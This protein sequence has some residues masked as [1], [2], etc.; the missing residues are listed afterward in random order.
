MDREGIAGRFR[1]CWNFAA[2]AAAAMAVAPLLPRN[3]TAVTEIHCREGFLSWL[4]FLLSFQNLFH[5]CMFVI[6]IV[7]GV[8]VA[9]VAWDGCQCCCKTDLATATV[10]FLLNC[11]V[12]RK[13][14]QGLRFWLLLVLG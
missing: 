6:V 1:C 8:L 10:L 14:D 11:C 9:A 4:S 7:A 12:C 5:C 3:A 13:S 2:A